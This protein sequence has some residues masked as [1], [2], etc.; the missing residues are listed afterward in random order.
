MTEI[1][2][3]HMPAERPFKNKGGRPRK[4]KQAHVVATPPA[5]VRGE[6]GGFLRDA[7]IDEEELR[8]LGAVDE[9]SVRANALAKEKMEAAQRGESLAGPKFS[10]ANHARRYDLAIKMFGLGMHV[11]LWRVAPTET[12]LDGK[13]PLSRVPTWGDLMEHI[14]AKYWDGTA[15]VYGWRIHLN[16]TQKSEGEMPFT[17]DFE[18]QAAYQ[19]R[20]AIAEERARNFAQQRAMG[21]PPAVQ[22]PPPVPAPPPVQAAP[23]AA[24]PAP[25]PIPKRFCSSCGSLNDLAS[26]FCSGCGVPMGAAPP[27]PQPAAPA[28]PAPAPPPPGMSPFEQMIWAELQ[29]EKKQKQALMDRLLTRAEQAAAAAPAGAPA[30]SF[31]APPDPVA[32]MRTFASQAEMV[33]QTSRILGMSDAKPETP[34]PAAARQNP[35]DRYDIKDDGF[36]RT[37]ID[38]QTGEIRETANV[39]AIVAGVGALLKEGFTEL[40]NMAAEQRRE[41]AREMREAQKEQLRLDEA[42]IRLLERKTRAE[43]GE[44]PPPEPEP[45]AE[46]EEPEGGAPAVGRSFLGGVGWRRRRRSRDGSGSG[47]WPNRTGLDGGTA[48]PAK[49]GGRSGSTTTHRTR[50]SDRYW[51]R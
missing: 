49:S 26:K 22:Q 43:R 36:S 12:Q 50:R 17:A 40:R 16:G 51:K 30:H 35:Y 31:S 25:A 39:S 2:P 7:P 18:Q 38:K 45:A 47:R 28:A 6:G 13:L 21:L 33:R 20:I 8:R 37:L 5:A 23:V 29:E 41:Q 24:A 10:D 32:Q 9:E 34:A 19:E 48:S 44:P 27:Q 42:R 14:R 11:H 15:Q 4:P 3:E 1:P 46:E